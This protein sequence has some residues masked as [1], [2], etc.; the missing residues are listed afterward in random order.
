M[1]TTD[2]RETMQTIWLISTAETFGRSLIYQSFTIICMILNIQLLY[3]ASFGNETI[4]HKGQRAKE[5]RRQSEGRLFFG[6]RK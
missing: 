3:L 4:K 5:R 2:V 6:S 1:Q